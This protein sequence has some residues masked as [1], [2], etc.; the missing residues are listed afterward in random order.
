MIRKR[1]KKKGLSGINRNKE[2][3]SFNKLA[4]YFLYS[5]GQISELLCALS[6][7]QRCFWK[8]FKCLRIKIVEI[9]L[10][11]TCKNL[12]LLAFHERKLKGK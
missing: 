8:H 11:K 12:F 2:I 1:K 6:I 5:L 9:D 7:E 4:T 3:D 10:K